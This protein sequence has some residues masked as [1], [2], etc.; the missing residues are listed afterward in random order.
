MS[1][2]SQKAKLLYIGRENYKT[3]AGY[4]E[5]LLEEGYWDNPQRVLK[6]NIDDM[7]SMYVQAVLIQLGLYCGC[8]STE[9]INFILEISGMDSFGIMDEKCVQAD[10][11]MLTEKVMKAPP[12]LLQLCGLRDTQKSSCMAGCFFDA[13][14]NI[15]LSMAEINNRRD[16]KLTSFIMGYFMQVSAF[17]NTRELDYCID[18]RYVFRKISCENLEGSTQV[19]RIPGMDFEAY[20]ERYI[21]HRSSFIKGQEKGLNQSEETGYPNR[22]QEEAGKRELADSDFHKKAGKEQQMSAPVETLPFEEK[23]DVLN[24][25]LAEL[26]T[27]IGL[28]NVK[29]EIKSLINLI[30]VRKLR[31]EYNMPLTN[32][33][34]HMVYTGNPGTGKTTVARLV[35]KIYKE[36]GILSEG[37]LVETD[38]SG[39]VAGYVG[40][41]ALKVKEVVEEAIGG[42]LFI[43]EAYAL[44]SGI[45]TSDFGGEA[46]DTLVKLMEDNRD[47]LVVIVAGY[48]EEMNEFLKSNTGLISRFN[49]FIDFKDYTVEEL[50]LIL[51]TMA[52]SAGLT[53]EPEAVNIVKEKLLLLEEDKKK[54]FG[55]GRGIRNIFEKIMVNQAN[56]LMTNEKPTKEQLTVIAV[57]DT[58]FDINY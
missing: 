53:M 10:I 44:A 31:E 40:Q 18:E 35:A 26:N 38:R 23:Q 52:K 36:L 39:L 58:D 46:I 27:L 25:L 47:N 28:E 4:C 16:R 45:G 8:F 1:R 43:D 32:I 24:K 57:Q 2:I 54:M 21:F 29:E 5:Q 56:R 33:S 13:L 14:L 9:E 7:L 55:N 50:L 34:Y 15:L 51:K 41:T 6:R 17:L 30:K 42:V 11:F 20:K 12:I 37:N 49:R 48:R 19:L 3:L 22:L